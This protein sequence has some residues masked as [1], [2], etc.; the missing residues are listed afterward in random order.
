MIVVVIALLTI[1]SYLLLANVI[2]EYN[3]QKLLSLGAEMEVK[4]EVKRESISL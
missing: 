2:K 1:A 4:D 3:K